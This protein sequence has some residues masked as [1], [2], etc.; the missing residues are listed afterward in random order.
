M[1][2]I[3]TGAALAALLKGL[4][5]SA[6][7]IVAMGSQNTFVFTQGLRRQ[8]HWPI[9]ALCALIDM[10]LIAVG[11]AGMGILIAQSENWMFAARIGGAVFL[12]VY[13]AQSLRKALKPQVFKANE[14]A[15]GGLGKAL[16]VTLAIT[17][18]N[19]HVYL[20]TVVLL[21]SIGGQ[22]PEPERVWFA[23]GAMGFSC[24]WFWLLVAGAK[25]CQPIFNN[26]RSWQ[27]MDLV[28]CVTM[29][30]IA[31]TL[32]WPIMFSHSG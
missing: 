7:L 6:G 5:T 19:P 30:A 15:L 32:L 20:D 8:F 1:V 18:L 25:V 4:A 17:L 14:M 28:I 16:I 3:F 13:G 24:I 22:Y 2:S 23:I 27:V 29:W 26:P 11:V 12:F 10:L 31:V 21:G 9:A